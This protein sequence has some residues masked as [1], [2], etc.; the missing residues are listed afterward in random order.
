[1][2]SGYRYSLKG[3][4]IVERARYVGSPNYIAHG[5]STLT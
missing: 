5:A 1:M 2:I 3:H 4:D